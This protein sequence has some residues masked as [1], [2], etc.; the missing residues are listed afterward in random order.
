MTSQCKCAKKNAG[1]DI[2]KASRMPRENNSSGGDS[3]AMT[4]GRQRVFN[5][6][7]YMHKKMLNEKMFSMKS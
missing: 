6:R 1:N 7:C 4:R 5:M 3:S 2:Q